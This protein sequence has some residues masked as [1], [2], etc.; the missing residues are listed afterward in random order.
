MSRTILTFG[1]VRKMHAEDM[2]MLDESGNLNWDNRAGA[3]AKALDNYLYEH[4]NV[5]DIS[6]FPIDKA[7]LYRVNGYENDNDNRWI[8]F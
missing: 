2:V 4:T 8:G 5:S 1:D 7:T 6:P 3:C